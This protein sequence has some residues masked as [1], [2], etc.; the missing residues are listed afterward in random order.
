MNDIFQPFEAARFD[1]VAFENAL[2]A[3]DLFQNFHQQRLDC[4][5]SARQGLKHQPVVIAVDDD[6]WQ[7]VR[8]AVN[9]TACGLGMEPVLTATNGVP[10]PLH[11]ESLARRFGI[12]G[13]ETQTNLRSFTVEGVPEEVAGRIHYSDDRGITVG[14]ALD[15]PRVNPEMPVAQAANACGG[16][17]GLRPH[18]ERIQEYLP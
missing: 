10:D 5:G 12:P 1:V 15:V 7:Q 4:I 9:Q 13:Q 16:D 3:E 6:R 14:L 17:G 11:E 8:L 18:L 2:R